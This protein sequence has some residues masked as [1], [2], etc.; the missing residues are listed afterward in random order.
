MS[1]PA[2]RSRKAKS[3]IYW[4]GQG[5][6]RRAYGDFRNMGGGQEALIPDGETR[7]T[8]DPVVAEI[9]VAKRLAE[10]QQEKTDGGRNAAAAVRSA[11][12][13]KAFVAEHLVLKAKSGQFSESWLADSERMLKLA[14]DFFGEAIEL[15]SITVADV[16]A[17]MA[18]LQRRASGRTVTDATGAKREGTL[19]GGAIRHHI[20]VLSNV[21]ARAQSTGIVP[22]GYNPVASIMRG[23]KPKGRPK[24]ANWL[25]IDDAARLLEAARVYTPKRADIATPFVYP[26]LATHLLTGG[27]PAEVRGLQVS[28]VNF[29]R[30]TITFRP[31][32]VRGLKTA[33]SHRTVPLWPQLEQILRAYLRAGD[34]PR[35]AG[36]LFPARHGAGMVTDFRKALDAVAA[37]AGWKAGD[38]RPYAFRHTYTAA[39]LQTLDNGAP[40]SSFTVARELG[41]GGDSLVKRVYGHLGTVRHRSEVVEYRLE[42]HQKRTG[43]SSSNS[44]QSQTPLA[45]VG[46]G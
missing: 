25:E 16:Q 8:T 13:L 1:T 12:G 29:D 28:D 4:R 36:L 44:E 23:E 39:R 42:Q 15:K 10:L 22:P 24:E 31:N 32:D 27:R 35:V 43:E 2:K 7:A 38:V 33:T 19:G 5:G 45:L 34:T 41:H 30:K 14:V 46:A 3:R 6:E 9:L 17:W 26:W 20:N 21:Y 37:L 18:L 11:V 40:V